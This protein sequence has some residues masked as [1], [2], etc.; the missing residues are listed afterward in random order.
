[1]TYHLAPWDEPIFQGKTAAIASIRVRGET[2]AADAF[3]IFRDWCSRN[4]VMLVCC[5]LA[6]DQLTECGFLEKQG[7]RFIE[8]NYRPTLVGLDRFSDDTE[9]TICSSNAVRGSRDLGL[10]RT[11]LFYRPPS[12]R[13]AGWPRDRQPPLWRLGGKRLPSS[14]PARAEMSDWQPHCRLHGGRGTHTRHQ[15]LVLGW[16]GTGTRRTWARA[17]RLAG[18]A[19][20]PSP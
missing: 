1:M 2:E 9:I 15:V 17:A 12:R 8:L 14:G 10:C 7:F 19:G 4:H 20:L 6:Q 3:G 5:R 16:P 18:Y 11:N 13:S